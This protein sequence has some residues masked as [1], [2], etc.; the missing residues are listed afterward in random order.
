METTDVSGASN[1]SRSWSEPAVSSA[2]VTPG[3]PLR[4]E[5][6][7]ANTGTRTA[8]DVVQC[9]V[10]PLDA[11]VSRPHQELKAFAKVQLAAGA[12]ET[13][14]LELDDRAFSHWHTGD[15]H[16]VVGE[17]VNELAALGASMAEGIGTLSG[18]PRGWLMAPG[19]Y[20]VVLARSAA[21]PVHRIR[22][23]VTP[24]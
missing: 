1:P 13:V 12:K 21:D 23:R 9:Y 22:V 14:H 8:A 15:D 17:P 7:V 16:A 11:P 5:L 4:I 20:D 18:H 3:G 24:S 10:V 19:E 2:T 6:T